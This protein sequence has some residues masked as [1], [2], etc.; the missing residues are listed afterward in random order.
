M[1][2]KD[3]EKIIVHL[4]EVEKNLGSMEAISQ[5]LITI[6]T[7]LNEISEKLTGYPPVDK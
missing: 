3:F 6:A 1:N 2:K 5:S 4:G 7:L